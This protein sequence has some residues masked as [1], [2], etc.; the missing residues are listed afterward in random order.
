[1]KNKTL[2]YVFAVITLIL[3]CYLTVPAQNVIFER[4]DNQQK[5]QIHDTPPTATAVRV[6]M[7]P[8]TARS[9]QWVRMIDNHMAVVRML[10]F[11]KY[12]DQNVIEVWETKINSHSLSDL[13]DYEIPIAKNVW[14]VRV[15]ETSNFLAITFMAENPLTHQAEMVEVDIP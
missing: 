1:M 11:P 4:S 10:L 8:E 13:P 9:Y 5:D 3:G 7:E 15:N 6:T 12:S 14:D 2:F